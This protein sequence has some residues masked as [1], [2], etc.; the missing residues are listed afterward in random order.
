MSSKEFRA[1]IYEHDHHFKIY[2]SIRADLNYEIKKSI[3]FN[4]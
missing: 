1:K 4:I 2:K 3:V